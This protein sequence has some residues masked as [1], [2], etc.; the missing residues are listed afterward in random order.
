M[1]E[2][3]AVVNQYIDCGVKIVA[4]E[5]LKEELDKEKMKVIELEQQVQK[6]TD[7][8]KSSEEKVKYLTEILDNAKLA[9]NTKALY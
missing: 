4:D 8:L 5:K 2:I 1:A 6:L 7:L 3:K 9:T